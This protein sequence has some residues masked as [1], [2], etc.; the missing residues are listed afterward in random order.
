MI[1]EHLYDRDAA[2]ST[3][4][5]DRRFLELAKQVSTWSKDPSTQVGAVL[6]KD[7]KVAG[8]GY[9]G[10]P[11]GVEDSDERYEN[12]ELKYAI[13]VHAEVNAILQAGH[14][15]KGST[16]YVYPSFMLP[17]VCSDCAGVAIQAGILG[18]VGYRPDLDD[19]R[20][21]RW[22]NSISIAEDMW[23]EAGLF[24]RSYDES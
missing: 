3:E 2:L 8:L 6:V 12:R 21:Q 19:P 9:N 10:F 14:A 20:V 1:R 17:P 15:A 13:V 22:A 24:I 7:G 5:W 11:R 4:K 23:Q 16:L 18:V